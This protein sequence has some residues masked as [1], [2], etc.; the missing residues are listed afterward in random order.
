[1]KTYQT[2]NCFKNKSIVWRDSDIDSWLS[3][4][5]PVFPKEKSIGHFNLTRLMTFKEIAR[6]FMG[7]DDIEK[8]KPH[9]FS[10]QE[11]EKMLVKKDKKLLTNGYSN[12]FFVE[13][14]GE[15]FGCGAYW[16]D[17]RWPGYGWRVLV[18]RFVDARRCSAGHRFFSRN[19]DSGKLE[20]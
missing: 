6:E 12:I 5:L 9:C 20:P 16:R 11:I 13:S 7:S 19:L 17:D 15:V 8:V 4:T 3:P 14:N 2:K 10:L 18:Y 1:M